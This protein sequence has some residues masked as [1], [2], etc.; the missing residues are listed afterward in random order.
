MGKEVITADQ[1]LAQN[2]RSIVGRQSTCKTIAESHQVLVRQT[3]RLMPITQTFSKYQGVRH[4][5][6]SEPR[7]T[8]TPQTLCD[9]SNVVVS[10]NGVLMAGLETL[11]KVTLI[12]SERDGRTM[13][14]EDAISAGDF[15]GFFDLI[16]SFKERLSANS[17]LSGLK[18]LAIPAMQ[19]LLVAEEARKAMPKLLE[20]VATVKSQYEATVTQ[21]DKYLAQIKTMYAGLK[22]IK[23]AAADQIPEI[24]REMQKIAGE[25]EQYAKNPND[26]R[27]IAAMEGTINRLD[28]LNHDIASYSDKVGDEIGLP[29]QI[30]LNIN[31]FM[32]LMGIVPTSRGNLEFVRSAAGANWLIQTRALTYVNGIVSFATETAQALVNEQM[33]QLTKEAM[34]ESIANTRK[35]LVGLSGT[36]DKITEDGKPLFE[37]PK[38]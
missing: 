15:S 23:G 17:R 11:K 27:Q 21:G 7:E 3:Q 13:H 34:Q 6:L 30:I 22:A 25:L 26:K 9:L 20:N 33:G 19:G 24:D 29:N 4:I 2:L 31:A 28:N 16:G 10:A 32:N 8:I 38:Q 12:G 37:A 5:P 35:R 36:L 14:I 18:K 1:G